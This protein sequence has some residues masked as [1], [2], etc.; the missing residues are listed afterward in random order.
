[1]TPS[2]H[3][4]NRRLL[5]G[6]LLV[7]AMAAVLASTGLAPLA[8]AADG[9]PT[10]SPEATS[11]S[12]LVRRLGPGAT[13]AY[14]GSIGLVRFIG[15]APGRPIA[16]PDA[17]SASASSVDTARAFLD[18][19]GPTRPVRPFLRSG[20]KRYLAHR[21]RGRPG[22]RLDPGLRYLSIRLRRASAHD[23]CHRSGWSDHDG[24]VPPSGVVPTVPASA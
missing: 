9:T 15:T 11:G 22:R 6:T 8:G 10:N 13:V 21:D 7:T 19:F 2:Y 12:A 24:D 17:V 23:H 18:S 3:R 5:S 4:F 14:H 20:G 1:M 16:R